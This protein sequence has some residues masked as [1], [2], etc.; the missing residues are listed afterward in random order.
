M[1]RGDSAL[2]DAEISDEESKGGDE[3]RIKPG[4]S[5]SLGDD[6]IAM[7]SLGIVVNG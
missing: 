1:Y 3:G 6:L 5:S 4:Y 7:A 2:E